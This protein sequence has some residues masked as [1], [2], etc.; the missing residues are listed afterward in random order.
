[1]VGHNA[2]EGLPFTNPAITND[3]AFARDLLITF[4]DVSPSVQTYIEEDLYSAVYDGSHDYKDE[5]RR[6]DLV[7]SESMFT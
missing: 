6:I 7:I 3:S 5:T 4:P 1:M 2:D